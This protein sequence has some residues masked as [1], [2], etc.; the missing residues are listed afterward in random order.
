[1]SLWNEY[2]EIDAKKKRSDID[3]KKA[4]GWAL[5]MM[6]TIRGLRE[7]FLLDSITKGDGN[8]FPTAILQ[9]LR[10]PEIIENLTGHDPV[11]LLM[12]TQAGLRKAVFQFLTTSTHLL[13]ETW[14]QMW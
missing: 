14:K 7:E 5:R 10:R 9:Q 4:R 3:W 2:N 13:I 11:Q 1:M 6:D 12:M 8:C